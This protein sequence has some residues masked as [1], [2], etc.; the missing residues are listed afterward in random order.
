MITPEKATEIFKKDYK[1]YN[2]QKIEKILK[3]EGFGYQFITNPGSYAGPLVVDFDGV[4]KIMSVNIF[5]ENDPFVKAK[6]EVIF[7]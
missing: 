7:G 4:F 6:S 1:G 3:V 2:G 5:N